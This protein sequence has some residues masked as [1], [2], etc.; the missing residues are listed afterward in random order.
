[1]FCFNKLTKKN[2]TFEKSDFFFDGKNVQKLRYFNTE[3]A[4]KKKE[5]NF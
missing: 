3:F 5:L 2:G 4:A 1:M